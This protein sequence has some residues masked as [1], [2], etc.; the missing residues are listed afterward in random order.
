MAIHETSQKSV[1]KVGSEK[2]E[3]EKWFLTAL[4]SVPEC[5]GMGTE[6]E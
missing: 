2:E 6:A 3:I 1:M 4:T 5:Y